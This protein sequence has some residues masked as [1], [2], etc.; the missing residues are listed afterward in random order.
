MIV[1]LVAASLAALLHVYIFVM[2]S[3]LW[4][5]PRV[6]ATFG[7]TSDAQA[8]HTKPLALNQ[9]FYNLFLAIVTAVGV[10]LVIAGGGGPASAASP[11]GLAL[12]LAGTGSMLAAA[13]VLVVTDRSKARAAATQGLF[14]LVTLSALLVSAVA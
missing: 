8:E 1:A 10:A 13:L 9:G 5:T 12:L 6:R 4:T 14:P 2:E 3:V 11:A 7:I